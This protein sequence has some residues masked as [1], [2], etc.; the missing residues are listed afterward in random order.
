M[1]VINFL[2][3]ITIQKTI[4]LKWNPKIINSIQFSPI[5]SVL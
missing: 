3:Y 2:L 5:N 4:I 1:I